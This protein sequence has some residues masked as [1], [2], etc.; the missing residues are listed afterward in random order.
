MCGS[1]YGSA[2]ESVYGVPVD[3][4]GVFGILTLSFVFLDIQLGNCLHGD[5]TQLRQ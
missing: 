5:R 4:V 2:G 1:V 3:C